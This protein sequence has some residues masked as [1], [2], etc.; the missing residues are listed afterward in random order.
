MKKKILFILNP[1]AGTGFNTEI[2]AI[3]K[4]SCNKN[5]FDAEIIFTERAGHAIELAAEAVK[6]KFDIVAAT[7]G[8]GT[9]NEVA[10]S[11][12]NTNTALAIIPTG[13]GN[14]FARHFN[15]PLNMEKAITVIKKGN[16]VNVDSLLIN[17]K[18]CMNIAGAGFD[19]YIAHL[20]ANYG[21]RGFIS[22]IKLVMKE[23][24]SYK[25]KNYTIEFDGKKINTTA[26][27][28]AIA[29]ASQFGNGA[30]IA[31][32]A[33]VND[34]IIDVTI[35]KKIPFYQI[36]FVM[37]KLFNGK[38]A[39]SAY[40]EIIRSKSFIISSDQEIITHIDGEPGDSCNEIVA[41]VDPLSVKL[42]VP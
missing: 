16:M 24:F 8:D 23:Y 3:I 1:K 10:Q 27:L 41:T 37:V 31:P 34:G 32:L 25:Q 22:Y 21:K 15:I 29:N 38:L 20:F 19:A 18:F 2:S 30:K 14:G 5:D 9:I 7:G 40:A 13:S 35:L 11:L 26:F 28:I 39:G 33:G 4:R 36:V 42:I 6:N 12:K 17:G